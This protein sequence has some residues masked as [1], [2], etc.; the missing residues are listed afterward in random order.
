LV[1][2]KYFY[3]LLVCLKLMTFPQRK[4]LAKPPGQLGW[5]PYV[6]CRIL[7]NLDTASDAKTASNYNTGCY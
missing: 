6:T 4:A 2:F 5:L 1:H 7:Q 3:L